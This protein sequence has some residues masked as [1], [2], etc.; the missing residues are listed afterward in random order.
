MWQ[1]PN[2]ILFISDRIVSNTP[3]MPT[4]GR[5]FRL[6]QHRFENFVRIC[7]FVALTQRCNNKHSMTEQFRS[8]PDRRDG[9]LQTISTSC[10]RK[11]RNIIGMCAYKY[12]TRLL[13]IC[14]RS[15][16]WSKIHI[17]PDTIKR[18]RSPWLLT[19]NDSECQRKSINIFHIRKLHVSIQF[20]YVRWQS[21]KNHHR[22]PALI[23]NFDFIHD[24]ISNKSAGISINYE[25]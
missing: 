17:I 16:S 9:I 13:F 10:N 8:C 21:T 19:A 20:A 4:M 15:W 23:C 14:S 6:C 22:S 1:S 3:I 5:H 7:F 2:N 25:R 18:V 11:M 12:Y 24:C